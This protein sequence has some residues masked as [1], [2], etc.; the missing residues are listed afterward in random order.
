[1]VNKFPQLMTSLGES[2]V[3]LLF[4]TGTDDLTFPEMPLS[5]RSDFFRSRLYAA[6]TEQVELKKYTN[7]LQ[8]SV[9]G[10]L[11]TV[12]DIS[13]L[14]KSCQCEVRKASLGFMRVF[15]CMLSDKMK[16]KF[17]MED[18][19]YFDHLDLW[20]PWHRWHFLKIFVSGDTV[21]SSVHPSIVT[22]GAYFLSKDF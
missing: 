20:M 22:Q 13:E 5:I 11:P 7:L 19:S 8:L 18:E 16:A 2:V 10:T 1:M 3:K 4:G 6:F 9:A 17:L 15:V 12:D 21:W 14:L